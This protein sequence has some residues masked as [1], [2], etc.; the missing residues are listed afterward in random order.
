MTT[1]WGRNPRHQ[2]GHEK[3]FLRK[4]IIFFTGHMENTS[5]SA[6]VKPFS[7]VIVITR[8]NISFSPY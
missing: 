8:G 2:G 6:T 3:F 1:R 5:A 7:S 4:T